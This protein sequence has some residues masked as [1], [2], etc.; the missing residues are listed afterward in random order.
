M[1]ATVMNAR[2]QISRP[3]GTVRKQCGLS[4]EGSSTHERWV[5]GEIYIE[6]LDPEVLVRV[7]K[8]ASYKCPF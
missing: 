8:S 2:S 6:G 4:F 5:L 3:L 1:L 7:K